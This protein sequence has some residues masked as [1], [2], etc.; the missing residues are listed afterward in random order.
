M[1]FL[2][3]ELP[4]LIV[5][6]LPTSLLISSFF[7]G[8][9]PGEKPAS[10]VP[11]EAEE[12]SRPSSHKKGECPLSNAL[13]FSTGPAV[14]QLQ[15]LSFPFDPLSLVQDIPAAEERS[16]TGFLQETTWEL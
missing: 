5:S 11:A 15:L 6:A 3:V 1:C 14:P 9:I 4:V 7:T 13:S 10:H 2:N 8:A 16:H 12:L